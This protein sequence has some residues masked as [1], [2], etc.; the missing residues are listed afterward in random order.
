V[1]LNKYTGDVFLIPDINFKRQL[2]KDQRKP[3]RLWVLRFDLAGRLTCR[4]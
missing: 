3:K 4:F 1:F 2:R